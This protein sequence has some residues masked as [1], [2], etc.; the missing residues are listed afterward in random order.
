VSFVITDMLWGGTEKGEKMF[1]KS[2]M[3]NY[4][5]SLEIKCFSMYSKN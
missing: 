1:L 2:F 5:F 3:S 4:I